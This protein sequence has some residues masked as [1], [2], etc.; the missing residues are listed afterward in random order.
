MLDPLFAE[1]GLPPHITG[2][3]ILV[4]LAFLGRGSRSGR[5]QSD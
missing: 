1:L 4:L 2:A 5:R 3:V